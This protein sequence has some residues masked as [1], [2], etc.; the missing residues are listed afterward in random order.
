M[1]RELNIHLC[2]GS[3]FPAAPG[4]RYPS[5]KISL[6]D[7]YQPAA[8]R[9]N[10]AIVMARRALGGESVQFQLPWNGQTYQVSM[11]P[12]RK[13]DGRIIGAIGLSM[14]SR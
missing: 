1:D 13:S 9:E 6:Y 5:R 10:P 4:V 2:S 8:G 14:E 3:A 12:L 11:E 7:L